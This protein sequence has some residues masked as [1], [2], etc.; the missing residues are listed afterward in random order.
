MDWVAVSA[1]SGAVIAGGTVS[2]FIFKHLHPRLEAARQFWS[3]LVGVT[4]N[5]VTG[6]RRVP[7]LFERLDYLETRIEDRLDQQDEVLATQNN[8]LTG[9]N[10][11]LETIRHEVQFNNGS[12]VKDAV[13][14]IEH[15]IKDRGAPE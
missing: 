15:H 2:V 5:G 7:G 9:Q 1:I 6:Q 13:I 3:S 10:K 14:R 8:I 11:V 12:S 4:E